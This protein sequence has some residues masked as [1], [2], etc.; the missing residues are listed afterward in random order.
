MLRQLN[1]L[2][3]TLRLPSLLPSP[4]PPGA[5]ILSLSLSPHVAESPHRPSPSSPPGPLPSSPHTS[6]AALEDASPP[7]IC[8][9]SPLVRL[10]TTPC[11]VRRSSAQIRAHP[12]AVA[13]RV[14]SPDGLTE[15]VPSFR[16]QPPGAAGPRQWLRPSRSSPSPPRGSPTAPPHPRQGCASSSAASSSN[17]APTSTSM[18]PT[19]LSEA[20]QEVL[21]RIL[22]TTADEFRAAVDVTR[23]TFPGWRGTAVTT[24][25][26]VMFTF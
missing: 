5:R 18:S 26:H 3:A 4:P 11:S 8:S 13:P 23:T 25:Q 20:M 7:Q 2:A 22:L 17:R 21:S 12:Y 15:T 1:L 24:R 14:P 10:R 9:L 19:P 16:A 6:T